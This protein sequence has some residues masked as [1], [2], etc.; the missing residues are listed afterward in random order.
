MTQENLI[1]P[2]VGDDILLTDGQQL[3]VDRLQRRYHCRHS[4]AEERRYGCFWVIADNDE[5]YVITADVSGLYSR[6][7]RPCSNGLA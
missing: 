1:R 4:T 7:F 3:K 5:E 6:T 2:R